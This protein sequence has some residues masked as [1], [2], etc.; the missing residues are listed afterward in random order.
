MIANWSSMSQAE[1]DAAYNNNGADS[2]ELIVR[3]NAAAQAYRAANPAGLYIPTQVVPATKRK[4]RFRRPTHRPRVS[5]SFTA[6]TG[7]GT[8][9]K[10]S[11]IWPADFARTAGPRRFQ[12]TRLHRTPVWPKSSASCAPR[13][14]GSRRKG[15]GTV[16]RR[17]SSWFRDGRQA[18]TSRR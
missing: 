14:I 16:S 2:A 1:R 7:S 17:A 11:R 5:C 9:V 18:G 10:T 8:R 15:L 13:W 12:V 3:R 4:F 6:A